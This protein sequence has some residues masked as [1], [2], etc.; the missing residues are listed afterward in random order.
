MP[1]A[2]ER[3]RGGTG[4]PGCGPG[5]GLW[6]NASRFDRRASLSSRACGLGSLLVLAAYALALWAGGSQH[7]LGFAEYQPWPLG[8]D[9]VA[10]FA[11]ARWLSLA[12]ALG[13]GWGVPG[14][15]L[16]LLA[17]RVPTGL[18]LACRAFGLGI[19]YLL[20]SGLAHAAIVGRAPGRVAWLVLLAVPCTVALFV[21]RD[22]PQPGARAPLL[23]GL[24]LLAGLLAMLW[25]KLVIEGMNGDGTEAYELARSLDRHPLPRWD[26][27]RWE[28]PGR[29]GT[30]AVNPFLTNSYLVTSKLALLGRGEL[31]ARLPLLPALLVCV[32][33]AGSLGRS[34]MNRSGLAFLALLAAVYL[35]WNAYYVGYEP[36]FTDLAEPAATDTLM[37]ALWLTGFAEVAAGSVGLGVAL[38]LLASGVLYSAP[39]L[40]SVALATRALLPARP[41]RRALGWWC[42]TVSGATAAALCYG[43]M[44]GD[45]GDWVEQV[46]AE[47][48]QDFFVAPTTPTLP[49]ALRLLLM[50]GGLPLVAWW[51]H[52]RLSH[53]SKALLVAGSVYLALVL[54]SSHKNLHY[55]APLPFLLAPPALEA[56]GT[57][58][59]LAGCFVLLAALV[60]SWP[61]SSAIHRETIELGRI[62]C[63]EDLDYEQACLGAD[64]VYEALD[65]PGAARRFAVGKHTFVRYGM[66][67]GGRDCAF[68]LAPNPRPGWIPLAAGPLSLQARDPEVYAQWRLRQPP[69]P[70][71]WL[72]SRPAPAALSPDAADWTGRLRLDDGPGAALPIVNRERPEDGRGDGGRGGLRLLVPVPSPAPT[73][74]LLGLSE[75]A[76]TLRLSALVNGQRVD[77]PRVRPRSREILL[78]VRGPGWKRGWNVLE[79]IAASGQGLPHIEWI[80]VR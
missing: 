7:G 51:R 69:V 46:R 56:A 22:P 38:L 59:R 32:A 26:L 68:R 4:A 75:A 19:G 27:E 10:P 78:P 30:P 16:A 67:L 73:G 70:S 37:T 21:R 54:A 35:L 52:R 18:R 25:P 58:L 77:D 15:S 42:A 8:A 24:A 39:L 5:A 49:F 29:F 65:E 31:A 41:Q 76:G 80:E 61:A 12:L 3:V 11:P 36:P 62:T 6:S 63:I 50:T 71:S 1:V 9:P 43:W 64:V 34:R 23:L 79:L 13:L 20:A 44:T 53:D 14:L 74:L 72:F 17:R 40:A 33:L 48:W 28:E 45:L 57:R 2:R 60:W 47:Y 66:D 55:L